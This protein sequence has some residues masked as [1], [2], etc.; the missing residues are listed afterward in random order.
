MNYK[1]YKINNPAKE[2]C[3]TLVILGFPATKKGQPGFILR[4]RLDT[5]LQYIRQYKVG[6]I[7]VTGKA[8]HNKYEEAAVQKEYLLKHN[9]DGNMIVTENKSASTLDNALYTYRLITKLN[10]K[11]IVIITSH[12]HKRRAQHIF[13]HYFH[14]YKIVTPLPGAWYVI[15]HLPYYLWDIIALYRLKKNNDIIIRK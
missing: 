6:K 8:T 1:I 14:S 9:I 13:N 7:V 12:Y 10:L 2:K 5:A 11:H 3:E 4:S 15:K